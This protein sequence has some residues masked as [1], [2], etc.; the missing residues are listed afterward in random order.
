M[1]SHDLP[2]R[3]ADGEPADS[4][5]QA[6]ATT[7]EA[8]LEWLADCLRVRLQR[9]FGQPPDSPPLPA[10]APPLDRRDCPYAA[11]VHRHLDH[12]QRLALGP[13]IDAARN[14]VRE[15]AL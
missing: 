1:N 8:E 7:L 3:P 2:W 11:A 5:L 14:L 15:F 9:Y 10:D 13:G 4:L 6:A 12:A